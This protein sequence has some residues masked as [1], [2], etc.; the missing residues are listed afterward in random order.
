[1]FSKS[2]LE[3]IYKILSIVHCQTVYLVPPVADTEGA[4]GGT[5]TSFKNLMKSIHDVSNNSA[6]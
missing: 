3:I 4:G 6:H 2:P 1:M 5:S